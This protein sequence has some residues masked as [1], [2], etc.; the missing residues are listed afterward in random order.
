MTPQEQQLIETF[1]ER[2]TATQNV[3][4]D[5]QADA[6]IRSRL[7]NF[8]DAN[9]LLVQRCLL[10]QQALENAK[11]EIARLQNGQGAGGSFLGGS[12]SNSNFAPNP[13][14][15]PMQQP[16]PS[17]Y[18]NASAAS[19]SAAPAPSRVPGFLASAATTAAGVAGGMFLFDGIESLLGGGRHGGMGFD[20][21]VNQPTTVENITENN[22]YNG[23]DP[24]DSDGYS[25]DDANYYDDNSDMGGDDGG[26]I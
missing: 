14:P 21:G 5:P 10:L 3:A 12:S 15:S 17:Y 4:K 24:N 2:L 9:Y 1:L 25:N 16:T 7:Q 11:G 22:Y 6:L 13:A 19:A 18:S 26:W 20:A 23:P 8:S